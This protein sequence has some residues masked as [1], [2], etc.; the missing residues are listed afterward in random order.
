MKLKNP[1]KKGYV[2]DGWYLDELCTVKVAEITKGSIGAKEF[3]A[4]WVECEYTI[5]YYLNGGENHIL[6]P[7]SYGITTPNIVLENPTKEGY[8][9]KGWYSDS[10]FKKKVVTITEGS[11]GNKKL[12]ARWKRTI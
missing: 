10:K 12:Y 1:T 4:K 11:T 7:D 6:N 9:F 5:T 8:T 2:F 3:Y